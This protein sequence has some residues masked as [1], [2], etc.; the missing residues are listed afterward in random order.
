MKSGLDGIRRR[1][2]CHYRNAI[3]SHWRIENS[4]HWP[5]AVSFREEMYRARKDNGPQNINALRQ[6][7]HNLLKNK[8]TLKVDIQSKRRNAG[9]DENHLLKVL[10]GY[11]AIALGGGAP[12]GL[13]NGLPAFRL[14]V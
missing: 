2:N 14:L 10:P 9:W 12:A 8:R 4:L 7:G 11:D 13:G 5:L 6:I 1:W 3:R